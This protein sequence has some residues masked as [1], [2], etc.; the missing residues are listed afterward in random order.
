MARSVLGVHRRGIRCQH[1]PVVRG[2]RVSSLDQI[3]ITNRKPVGGASNFE[4]GDVVA[5]QKAGRALLEWDRVR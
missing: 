1:G 5:I 4:D 2:Q 3:N